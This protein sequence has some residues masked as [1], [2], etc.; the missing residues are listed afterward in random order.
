MTLSRRSCSLVAILGWLFLGSGCQDR[1]CQDVGIANGASYRVDI[2]E[3]YDEASRFTFDETHVWT[4]ANPVSCAGLDGLVAGTALELRVAGTVGNGVGTCR[5]VNA[6]LVSG[7]PEIASGDGSAM[8][9]EIAAAA[10]ATFDA[11]VVRATKEVTVAGCHGGYALAIYDGKVSRGG[12]ATPE[13]FSPPVPGELPS[14]ILYRLFLPAAGSSCTS[15][16]DN[17]V[18][19]FSRT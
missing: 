16:Q 11:V 3:R 19:Q 1:L 12:V 7:P 17:F 13:I 9:E 14:A 6:N 15:C 18:V 8:V 10:N 4:G 2:A 5:I